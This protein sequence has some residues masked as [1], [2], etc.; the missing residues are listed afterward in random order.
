M[1]SV[2]CQCT[3][4]DRHAALQDRLI[5]ADPTIFLRK[6]RVTGHHM[7]GHTCNSKS[8]DRPGKVAN[9]ARGQLN[10]ENEYFPCPRSRRRISN[11]G[12]L[13]TCT[14]CTCLDI[15]TS[16]RTVP[17]LL[18]RFVKSC[19]NSSIIVCYANVRKGEVTHFRMLYCTVRSDD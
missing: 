11:S 9:P 4:H 2:R 8:M 7:Y 10:K 16:L 1:C 6:P 5:V 3:A 19:I 17:D 12:I 18:P 14:T 15:P 13:Y